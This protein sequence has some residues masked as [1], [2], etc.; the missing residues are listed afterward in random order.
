VSLGVI[1]VVE[2]DLEGQSTNYF[3]C[4]RIAR[5]KDVD[6]TGG[7]GEMKTDCREE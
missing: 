5:G 1:M 3:R 6:Q 4:T 7:A 2:G